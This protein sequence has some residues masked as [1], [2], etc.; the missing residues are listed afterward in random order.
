MESKKPTLKLDTHCS[1]VGVLQKDTHSATGN[2][3]YGDW[4]LY[5]LRVESIHNE[6]GEIINDNPEDMVFFPTQPTYDALQEFG[7]GD[8]V[9]L[10]RAMH[11]ND[12]NV[13]FA[14][15]VELM[16]KG[17]G[18]GKSDQDK[19]DKIAEG[20]VRHGIS[21]E[22]YKMGKELSNNTVDEIESWVKYIMTGKIQTLEIANID[23]EV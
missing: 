5:D 4:W 17:S 18:S 23:D 1:A 6:D 14:Y 22:A 2:N 3:K 20:K 9:K 12:E 21:V 10:R 15:T 11:S 19:W 7:A 13:W 16:E 8:K